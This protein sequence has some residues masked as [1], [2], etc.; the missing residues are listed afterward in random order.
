M[1]QLLEMERKRGR[2]NPE[3]IGDRA[4]GGAFQSGFD[5]EAED[6]QTSSLGQRG[7]R[8][9]GSTGFHVSMIMET[10]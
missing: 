6:A 2:G 5:Q 1:A 8:D 7:E 10:M 4:N 9:K 3:R